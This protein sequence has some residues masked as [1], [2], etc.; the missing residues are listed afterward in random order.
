MADS[1]RSQPRRIR[2][3]RRADPPTVRARRPGPGRH[4]P[5]TA[6][7]VRHALTIFGEEVYY[8]VETVELVP[9]PT[10]PDRLLLGQLVGPGRILL[11]DQPRSP[12]R[13]GFDLAAHDSARLVEAGADLGETG[14]V[15]WPGETLK[16]FMLGHVLAHEL[17][18]HVLQHERRLRG[19]RAARTRD[20]EA[21]A[22][23]IAAR[24]RTLLD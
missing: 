5:A 12:W 24:L 3:A 18:H 6:A 16:R 23:A 4:H 8:G 2:A 13:L 21:R 15:A 20:H 10:E 22:G 9:A 19:E 11:Y 17:G 1:L 14:V 7:D